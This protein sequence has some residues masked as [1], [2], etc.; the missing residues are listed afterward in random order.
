[1]KKYKEVEEIGHGS[2]ARV[3][4]VE[5]KSGQKFAK[6]LFSPMQNLIDAVGEDHLKKRFKREVKYQS[7]IQHQNIV[8]ILGYE[9]DQ[10]PPYFIMP[11]A[12]C[13]LQE[14]L[15]S[16]SPL[17]GEYKKVLFDV[18]A[19]LE[20]MHDLGYVHRDLKPA[21]ILKFRSS[22]SHYYSISDFG[23]M[24]VAQSDSTTLT[25]S[26]VQGGTQYYAA[27]ELMK[28]FRAAT[29]LAD[30]YS[31][32]A[33]LHDI[34][35]NE[36]KRVPYTELSLPGP[37]GEIIKKCTKKVA[38]RRYQSIS[39]LRDELYQV[40]DDTEVEFSSSKEEDLVRLSSPRL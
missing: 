15:K 23:L 10:E 9:L 2:F 37:I 32:G 12:E 29:R 27:P 20:C 19:G 34:F 1:M 18:L 33:I 24:S 38:A 28:N 4:V 16:A 35:G 39:A 26:N 3:I 7:K 6:K 17:G 14:E 31:F 40:L 30:I 22:D 11:L 25:G 8:T 36:A 21:N 13:T 5:N